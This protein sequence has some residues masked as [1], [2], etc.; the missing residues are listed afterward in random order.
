[1]GTRGVKPSSP[2]PRCAGLAVAL[3]CVLAA[4]LPGRPGRLWAQDASSLELSYEILTGGAEGKVTGIVIKGRNAPQKCRGRRKGVS[5]ALYYGEPS[6]D[7]AGQWPLSAAGRVRSDGTFEVEFRFG[8]HETA[9]EGTWWAK[10]CLKSRPRIEAVLSPIIIG[11]EAGKEAQYNRVCQLQERRLELYEQACLEFIRR[12]EALKAAGRTGVNFRCLREKL[13]PRVSEFLLLMHSADGGKV[14]KDALAAEGLRQVAF[15]AARADLMRVGV[16]LRADRNPPYFPA[17]TPRPDISGVVRVAGEASP[18]KAL[19]ALGKVYRDIYAG[20]RVD[21]KAEDAAAAIRDLENGKVEM[22]LLG[23]PLTDAELRGF[24]KARGYKPA[25]VRLGRGESIVILVNKNN[26]LK[27]IS[28]PQLDAVFSADRLAG[29]AEDIVT[30]GQLGVEDGRWKSRPISAVALRADA[31][32][33]RAFKSLVLRG[34]R[35]KRGLNEQPDAE[36]VAAWVAEDPCAIGFCLLEDLK[37]TVRA[38]PISTDAGPVAPAASAV[39]RGE[40]PLTRYAYLYLDL[41]PGWYQW[42][43]GRLHELLKKQDRLLKEMPNFVVNPTREL[44]E[45]FK[46][47]WF[48][49]NE[50]AKQVELN[51]LDK[52]RIIARYIREEVKRRRKA[53]AKENEEKLIKAV[54]KDMISTFGSVARAGERLAAAHAEALR[55][56]QKQFD[57][58][59]AFLH[60]KMARIEDV[61]VANLFGDIVRLHALYWELCDAYEAA[62]RKFN[63]KGWQ[64]VWRDRV[65]AMRGAAAKYVPKEGARN[66]G[67]GRKIDKK[68]ARAVDELLKLRGEFLAKL[69]KEHNTPATDREEM[70]R[71]IGADRAAAFRKPYNEMRD[72]VRDERD[73]HLPALRDAVDMLDAK[74]NAIREYMAPYMPGAEGRQTP[75]PGEVRKWVK[76]VYSPEL[77]ALSESAYDRF[78]RRGVHD[79]F[80]NVS[81][82]FLPL[83]NKLILLGGHYGAAV[84]L[85][86]GTEEERKMLDRNL[87]AVKNLS[88]AAEIMLKNIHTMIENK[89]NVE[90]LEI[91]TPD[92]GGYRE[93][94][95]EESPD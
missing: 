3:L 82:L 62:R 33:A 46:T 28:L 12:A 18:A 74:F 48:L 89:Y 40:Y 79:L 55:K 65:E 83:V 32:A 53:G 11:S 44:E 68:M 37:S 6:D 71:N 39:E 36:A 80:P 87:L 75:D 5:V 42:R 26:P 17:Y 25:V 90:A 66:I 35:L 69:Y 31:P 14:M 13:E 64:V 43:D 72:I 76:D 22:A 61:T 70:P 51:N 77:L 27:E 41:D 8:R 21:F 20:V 56:T 2:R 4:V 47:L 50:V 81:K 93:R 91:Y 15:P 45:H 10:V 1:M 57:E 34:G 84:T 86:A 92:E 63:P 24:T 19:K 85:P 88:R 16:G 49:L 94:Y 23:R 38:V 60:A 7:N 67:R 59:A 52:D 30:W 78:A 95:A 73:K 54:K 9:N 29:Y 58:K